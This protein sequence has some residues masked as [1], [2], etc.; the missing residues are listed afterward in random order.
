MFIP[1]L[2][3]HKLSDI[4]FIRKHCFKTNISMRFQPL[5]FFTERTWIL[6]IHKAEF[7][8][9]TSMHNPT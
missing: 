8:S 3:F 9:K 4:K 5:K 1:N 7:D 6:N 2:V